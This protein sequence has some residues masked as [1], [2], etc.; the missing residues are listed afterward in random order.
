MMLRQAKPHCMTMRQAIKAFQ[1]SCSCFND[2]QT[3][4]VAFQ[5]SCS[6]CTAAGAHARRECAATVL[7]L[8]RCGQTADGFGAVLL[9]LLLNVLVL[10]L[11]TLCCLCCSHCVVCAAHT[12]L[13]VPL[14]AGAVS[15]GPEVLNWYHYI[16][17]NITAAHPV[18]APGPAPPPAPPPVEQHWRCIA[19]KCVQSTS[20]VSAADC[21]K[22]CGPF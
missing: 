18:P 17:N 9:A 15:L 21:A 13:S 16:G 6:C 7:D 20:G 5:C 11:L 10:V 2:E 19:N 8:D 3:R 22:D 1:Y 14:R 12:V 4:K